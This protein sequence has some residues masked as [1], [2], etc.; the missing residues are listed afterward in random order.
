MPRTISVSAHAEIS[1]SYECENCG[2]SSSYTIP[3]ASATYG[4][5]GACVPEELQ[6]Q[7]MENV[8]SQIEYRQ[9]N[10]DYDHKKCSHCGYLQSW[11]LE[12]YK[13]TIAGVPAMIIGT[14]MFFVMMIYVVKIGSYLGFKQ[15]VEDGLG[16]LLV[17]VLQ[18]SLLC[19]IPPFIVGG[20]AWLVIRQFAKRANP[21]RKFGIVKRINEPVVSISR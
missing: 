20:I 10:K 1:V 11:M 16:D 18:Y 12:S 15:V 8:S 4:T 6:K 13:S 17:M 14:I 21:N 9:K 7:V 2:K 3:I 5:E 19:L